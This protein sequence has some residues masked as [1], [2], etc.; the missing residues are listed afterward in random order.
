M[1]FSASYAYLLLY[2]EL[3]FDTKVSSSYEVSRWSYFSGSGWNVLRCL[4]GDVGGYKVILVFV[5]GL[6][7]AVGG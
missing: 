5:A 3:P 2:E 1:S 4:E 6:V 7:V